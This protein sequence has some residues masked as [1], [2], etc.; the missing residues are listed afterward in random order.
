[1]IPYC[2]DTG[3]GCIPWSPI[4]RGVLARP[5]NDRSTTIRDKTD[6][7]LND[8]LRARQDEVDK[9]IVDRLEEVAKKKGVK[10]AQ[11]ATA[12]TLRRGTIPIIGLGS[13]ERIDEAVAA[14]NVVLTDE[15]AKYL[16]EPYAPKQIF[17]Y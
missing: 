15:E 3:V 6:K 5:W 4:A 12:W 17:G 13:T 1:M 7:F 16:E 14:I 10:M 11:V 9:Q 8:G 2:N